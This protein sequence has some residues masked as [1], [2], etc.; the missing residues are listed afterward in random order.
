MEIIVFS[1]STLCAEQLELFPLAKH[2]KQLYFRTQCVK[3]NRKRQWR[4]LI[5]R[6]RVVSCLFPRMRWQSLR[7]SKNRLADDTS[8]TNL[9]Y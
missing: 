9:Y 7:S 3:E 8:T 1:E 4:N 5:Q 6:M 2:Q